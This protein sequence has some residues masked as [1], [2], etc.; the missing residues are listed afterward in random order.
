VILQSKRELDATKE[1][2]RLIELQYES[3]A[4]QNDIGEHAKELTLRSLKG[5][6]NQMKE[7]IT[8]YESHQPIAPSANR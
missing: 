1:K 7:E 2:L 6:I 8:F 5:L 4:N 3:V